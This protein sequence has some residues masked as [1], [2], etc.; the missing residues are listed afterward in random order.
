M[1]DFL[2]LQ[3]LVTTLIKYSLPL[4]LPRTSQRSMESRDLSVEMCTELLSQRVFNPCPF[5]DVLPSHL[6][7]LRHGSNVVQ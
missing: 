6:S 5:V 1:Y 2:Q 7:F 4:R 3:T